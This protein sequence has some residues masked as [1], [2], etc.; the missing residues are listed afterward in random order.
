MPKSELFVAT[1][2]SPIFSAVNVEKWWLDGG[3]DSVI[4]YELLTPF[5]PKWAP[6]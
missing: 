4:N 1:L 3:Q 5:Y 6:N 2:A